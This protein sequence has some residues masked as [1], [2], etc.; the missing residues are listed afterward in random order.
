M[1]MQHSKKLWYIGGVIALLCVGLYFFSVSHHS[2]ASGTPLTIRWLIAHEPVSLFDNAEMAFVQEF[3]KDADTQVQIQV[4]G[5]KDF[6]YTTGI[7]PTDVVLAH[8]QSG[9]VQ[10]AT[11]I[12]S[13]FI[14]KDK[15]LAVLASP[16]AFGSNYTSIEKMLDSSAAVELLQSI[17]QN[18][19]DHA[20]AF[21]FSG[22]LMQVA[23]D[24]KLFETQADFKGMRIGTLSPFSAAFFQALGATPVMLDS[25]NGAAANSKL[26][27]NLDGMEIPYSRI[28]PQLP[29]GAPA[30]ITET[31]N[32]LFLTTMLASNA[33]YGSLSPRD[34][35]ALQKATEAAAQ[36]E[37]RDS[38]A[39]AK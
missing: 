36:V 32:S 35:Q 30:Y 29:G 8:L 24:K 23:S 21:T 4:L 14:S 9:D 18:F 13:G 31:N 17:G 20:L 26:L 19:P 27:A 3:N 38:V 37:R 28:F 1:P 34:Q 22:G 7:V 5:P 15:E 2:T 11:N 39:L 25:N 33:F 12:V 16:Y 10:M 6:G